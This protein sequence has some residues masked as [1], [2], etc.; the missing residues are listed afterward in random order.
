MSNTEQ[1]YRVKFETQ[2]R[3]EF[4]HI[5]P[6]TRM[7]WHQYEKLK[8]FAWRVYWAALAPKVSHNW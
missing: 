2:W 4:I 1:E 7:E 6:L 8:E 5:P 3:E